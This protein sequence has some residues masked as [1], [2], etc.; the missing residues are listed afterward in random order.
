MRTVLINAQELTSWDEFHDLFSKLF[1]FPDFYGRNMNAWID[2]MSDLDEGSMSTFVLAPEEDLII[3]IS[4]CSSL[5]GTQKAIF[6]AL[7]DCSCFINHRRLDV[8]ERPYI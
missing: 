4:N 8:G 3:A 5:S 7:V 1:G 6:E 2:C